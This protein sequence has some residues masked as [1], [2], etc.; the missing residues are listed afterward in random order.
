MKKKIVF[1]EPPNFIMEEF[2]SIIN[3]EKDELYIISNEDRYVGRE[4]CLRC[5]VRKDIEKVS[6]WISEKV[7]NPSAIITTS[8]MFVTQTAKLAQIYGLLR[9]PI[10]TALITRD[11]AKMKEV[12]SRF[13]IMTPQSKYY[14]SSS[15]LKKD[16]G[17][18]SFPVVIKPSIGYASCGVKKVNNQNELL[19][20]VSKIFLLNSTIF[21]KEQL[22][23]IG[24]LIEEYV[25]GVEF[26]IDTIWYNG[27]PIC[28][29][30]MSK[31]YADGPYYPDL[32]YYIDPDLEEETRKKIIDVSHRAVAATGL[33]YGGTH[34]EVRFKGGVPYVIES[35]SRPGGGGVFFPLFEKA[36][37]IT[38]LEIFYFIHLCNTEE[39]L[40]KLTIRNLTKKP[41]DY[42]FWYN[43]PSKKEG[44]IKSIEGLEELRNRPEILT[45]TCFKRPGNVMYQDDMNSDYFCS[46]SGKVSRDVGK[47]NLEQFVRQYE[48][49][50]YILF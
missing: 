41:V 5:D 47:H 45:Y 33:K 3:R 49:I 7:K 9:N 39:E 17:N 48:E 25:D 14:F 50:V 38:F 36:Y 11:K 42:Y 30:I 6:D 10:E 44:I 21:V 22:E 27:K 20:Q 43:L 16:I 46:I 26:S 18:I 24:F 23:S 28:D 29:G 40:T 35:A 2:E 8:E 32:L 13:E 12:W 37:G 31:G 1:V 4:N 15:E 19:E 34:T